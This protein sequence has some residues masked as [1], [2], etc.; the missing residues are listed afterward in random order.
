MK[1]STL[2]ALIDLL[3]DPDKEVYKTVKNELIDQGTDII[4]NLE[5]AW[6]KNFNSL[7]QDRVEEIIREIQFNSLIAEL[8]SWIASPK[9][10]L[11]GWLI[12]S[13]YQYPELKIISFEEELNKIAEE[14]KSSIKKYDSDLEKI[15]TLNYI[16]F[17]KYGFRG[18]MRNFHSPENS[19]IN[20][21]IENKKGN[22]LSLSIIYI[23]I[24]Q[25][26]GLPI[27]GVNMPKHFIVGFE[28]DNH[29]DIDSIKFYINPFSRGT[30]LNRQDLE[31]FL[32]REK[33]KESSKYFSP[34]SNKE[35]LKRL[36]NNLLHSY[37]YRSKKEKAEDM[38]TFLQL[39][40]TK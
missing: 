40:K 38:V 12:I 28:S 30:I 19:F 29:F 20:D 11:E 10:L 13:R 22:P 7:T 24:C 17:N 2:K 16:L 9:N 15:S 6:E 21:V 1:S 37:T 27:C 3:E 18:N 36:I 34:C 8:K 32:K 14:A 5:D 39:F 31:K 25:K 4:P 35:I 23:Y 26:I 33:I